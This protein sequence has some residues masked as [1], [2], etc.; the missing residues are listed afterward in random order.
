MYIYAIHDILRPDDPLNIIFVGTSK[1]PWKG[2]H[3]Q[4]IRPHNPKMEEWMREVRREHPD[5]IE[6]LGKVIADRYHGEVVDLPENDEELARLE[7]EILE[8]NERIYNPRGV[9]VRNL[10]QWWVKKLTEEGHQLFN[11]KAGRPPKEK[12]VIN[13]RRN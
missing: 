10:H 12:R 6:I 5:G 13:V 1:L 7:W 11:G 9:V 8:H 4:M 2:V 3:R